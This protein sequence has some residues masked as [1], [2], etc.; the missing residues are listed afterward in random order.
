MQGEL[1][2]KLMWMT[3]GSGIVSYRSHKSATTWFLHATDIPKPFVLL[4]L[5][6]G[7]VLILC[8]ADIVC[9]ACRR[10]QA[11]VAGFGEWSYT[12]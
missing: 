9:V 1:P 4:H 3:L 6:D 10:T 8:S 7:K 12:L 2:D 5:G 11:P